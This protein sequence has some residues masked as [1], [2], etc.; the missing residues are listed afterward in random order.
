MSCSRLTGFEASKA[1]V[2]QRRASSSWMGLLVVAG[3]FCV[4]GCVIW[5]WSGNAF[6]LAAVLLEQRAELRAAGL[7]DLDQLGHVGVVGRGAAQQ[8][9]V[10][11]GKDV[12]RLLGGRVGH[13][14]LGEDAPRHAGAREKRLA[15]HAPDAEVEQAVGMQPVVGAREDLEV[16]KVLLR[17]LR[18]FHGRLYVIDRDHEDRG[19]V[20]PGGAQQV[21][22]RR[23]AEIRL[24][25][26]LRHEIELLRVEIERGERYAARREY[27]ADDL[28]DAPEAGDD[29]RV[30]LARRR[31]AFGRGGDAPRQAVEQVDQHGRGEHADRDDRNQPV[32]ERGRQ[33]LLAGREG[34]STKAN[35]P[36]CD[37]T[38]A[39]A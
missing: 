20:G 33:E 6:Y 16:R 37:S 25:A 5:V 34:N 26:E 38:T 12:Y 15:P 9:L 31:A 19:L 3:L 1:R 29:H 17:D 4:A 35:S 39:S 11:Q 28:A 10:V 8:A 30:L 36:P 32:G 23:I 13:P 14:Q 24:L 22:A 18:A 7:G 2:L 27:A 21:E